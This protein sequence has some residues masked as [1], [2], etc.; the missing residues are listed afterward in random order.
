MLNCWHV[1][2]DG[3]I[4]WWTYVMDERMDSWVD[5]QIAWT[6][7]CE[8]AL[9]KT[10]FFLSTAGDLMLWPS[11]WL[12]IFSIVYCW[13]LVHKKKKNKWIKQMFLKVLL[14]LSV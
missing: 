10:F 11:D 1:S 5:K 9:F 2:A 4:Q 3:Q 8:T 12:T 14:Y 7:K 6:T 13:H